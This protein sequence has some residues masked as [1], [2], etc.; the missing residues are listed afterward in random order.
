MLINIH[1]QTEIYTHVDISMSLENIK[2]S[3]DT[4]NGLI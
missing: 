1:L 3:I 2:K 4:L